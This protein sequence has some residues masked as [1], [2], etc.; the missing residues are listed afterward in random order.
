M[1][2]ELDYLNLAVNNISLIEGVRNCESLQ[3]IDLTL[4][5]IDIEDLEESIDNLA[6]LPDLRELYFLGNPCTDWPHWKEYIIARIPT[7]GRLDGDD[8]TKTKK[9]AAKQNFDMMAQDLVRASRE[10]IEKK[11]LEDKL[12][13]DPNA[14]T[15]EFRKEV[16]LEELQRKA[17]QEKAQKENSMFKDFNEFEKTY[18]RKP[19]SVYNAKGEVR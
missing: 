13:K 2:K 17:D 11:V 15:K 9:M 7:L 18:E 12:P 1:C 19:V 14:Y 16:Y 4:N 5:F 3:K 8:V 10:R 6:E